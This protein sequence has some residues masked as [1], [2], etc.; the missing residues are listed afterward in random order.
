MAVLTNEP[1]APTSEDMTAAKESSRKLASLTG[2]TQGTVQIHIAAVGKSETVDLPKSALQ[3]LVR[4]LTEMSKGNAVTLTPI[5]AQLTTQQ[6]A[7]LLGVS[8][9]F[10]VKE[11]K[12][13][14]IP[15]AMVGT[16]RRIAYRDLLIY[17][18]KCRAG[19]D[20]AMDELAAHAQENDMGY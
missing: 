15:Y 18:E 2:G 4:I 16:H 11:L 17:R 6:V 8:R 1:L 10:I 9:P 19:H 5:H 7:D 13:G 20:Q 14:H 3:M 12:E